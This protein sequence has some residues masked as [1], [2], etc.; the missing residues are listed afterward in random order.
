M[1]PDGL[2]EIAESKRVDRAAREL[3]FTLAKLKMLEKLHP[4]VE[5][6]SCIRDLEHV[7]RGL[8]GAE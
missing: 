2:S 4:K 5:F 7:I 6:D 3:S 1:Q 8:R